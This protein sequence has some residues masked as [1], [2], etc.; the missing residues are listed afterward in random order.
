MSEEFINIATKEIQQ[1]I[2]ALETILSDCVSDDD[3]I[4]NASKFQKHTH[5]IKGLAPM[6]GNTSL[7]DL[8]SSMDSVFK[9]ISTKSKIAG[10][11]Q[12]LKKLIPAMNLVLIEPNSDVAELKENLS[13]IEK[14]LS[15]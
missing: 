14:I 4:L 13:Q 6:M 5:K 2:C 10:V 8:S 15:Q 11:F 7:G 1:D 3:V 9:I 12:F